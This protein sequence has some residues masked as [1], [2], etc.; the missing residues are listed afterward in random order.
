MARNEV[1]FI[2]LSE[3]MKYF[4][5]YFIEVNENVYM[6]M[7]LKSFELCDKL[8]GGINIAKLKE[9]IEGQNRARHNSL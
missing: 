9:F 7:E 2:Q 8:S 4:K 1:E 3:L 5:D 6:Y